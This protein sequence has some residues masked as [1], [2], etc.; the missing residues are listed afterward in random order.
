MDIVRRRFMLVL[1][2]WELRVNK[3]RLCSDRVRRVQIVVILHLCG[4]RL[5]LSNLLTIDPVLNMDT[6]GENP[7]VPH[8]RGVRKIGICRTM[9]RVGN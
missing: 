1:T 6:E 5:M 3:F 8:Y 4:F 7:C 2:S 9:S